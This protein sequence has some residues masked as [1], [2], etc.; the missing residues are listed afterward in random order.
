MS[1]RL[2]LIKE[3]I[4]MSK[5]Y[6]H[7][8]GKELATLSVLESSINRVSSE[9]QYQN[10]INFYHEAE[11]TASLLVNLRSSPDIGE[12]FNETKMYLA[13]LEWPCLTKRRIDLVLW[14]PGCCKTANNH[15]NDR[16]KCATNLPLL[17]AVQVK[18]GPGDLKSLSDTDKDLKDLETLYDDEKLGTPMLYFL[19]WVDHDLQED[20]HACRKYRDVQRRLKEWCSQA[21]NRRAFVISRDKIGFAYPHGRWLVNP[22][23]NGTIEN[24]D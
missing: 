2:F 11:L 7:R 8:T 10:A 12:Y 19:E 15:W 18:R 21:L 24:V 17:A 20:E 9:F 16:I 23:P 5:Y 6:L 14:K 3:D 1:I 22:L 4:V 13:H